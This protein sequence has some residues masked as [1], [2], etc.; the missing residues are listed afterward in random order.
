MN[1]TLS[2]TGKS[3]ADHVEIGARHAGQRIDNFLAGHLK[4]VPRSHLYRILRSGEVRVNSGR[5][6]PAYRLA[7]GDRVRIPPLRL[8]AVHEPPPAPAASI[9]QLEAAVLL[10]D[11]ALIVLDKPAGLA[12]HGGSG[13]DY[14]IIEILRQA[15]PHAPV[16]ELAHR[17]D[18]DTSGCL[19]IAKTREM[20]NRLHRLLRE[21]GVE[22][23]Y[24]ALVAGR[25]RGGARNVSAALTY[26]LQSGGRR[27]T[28]ID[29]AGKA[30]RSR[31][32]PLQR[33]RQ[34]TLMDVRIDT[35]RTH[36]IRVH[37][38]HLGHPVAG[39]GKYGDFAFN[40][41]LRARGLRRLF[42]HASRLDFVLP[43][44]GCP[45]HIE[46]PLAEDLVEVLAQLVE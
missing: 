34:A 30:A 21:G 26:D 6:K 20:L 32:K 24:L 40:R 7:T 22:K 25:W 13:L 17:L 5:I 18:R 2:R 31:F 41:E 14:G 46:A 3:R 43:D 44:S 10:E 4:G 38:V 16:L 29:T 36:Q 28:R 35:G 45:Y 9:G 33:Y 19:L 1:R 27:E 37:A 39:D 8:P 23:H 42:L 15:R 12:V 11:D